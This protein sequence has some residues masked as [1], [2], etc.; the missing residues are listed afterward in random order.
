MG[1]GETRSL[2]VA[3]TVLEF[4]IVDQAGLKLTEIP[5]PL[6]VGTKGMHRVQFPILKV[7][8]SLYCPAVHQPHPVFKTRASELTREMKQ[9]LYHLVRQ[10]WELGRLRDLLK[11]V[12]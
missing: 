10:T 9:M 5:M 11:S 12:V 1:G 6:G 4:T 3:L 8:V 7:R 2:H